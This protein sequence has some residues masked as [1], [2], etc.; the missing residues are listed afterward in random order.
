MEYSRLMGMTDDALIRAVDALSREERGATTRLVAH[1]AELARRGLPLELGYGGLFD[2]C[3]RKLGMSEG[4]AA[5]RA[6]AAHAARKRPGVLSRLD[7]GSLSLSTLCRLEPFLGDADGEELLDK[8]ARMGRPALDELITELRARRATRAAPAP[9]GPCQVVDELPLRAVRRDAE[10]AS[11]APAASQR[12]PDSRPVRMAFEADPALR[13]KLDL[14]GQLLSNRRLVP[15]V[16][17]LIEAMAD[18]AIARLD[19]SR[20]RKTGASPKTK[21][22]RI[23]WSVRREVWERDG[24]R[25]AY[26]GP[27]GTRCAATRRLQYDHV[28]PWALGGRSDDAGNIRL[29]CRAHNLRLGRKSFPEATARA[30]AARGAADGARA[31]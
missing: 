15:G 10:P 26:A 19:P 25:C 16:G 18:F 27:D 23:P 13:R 20:P 17:G 31:A 21:G 8:A 9:D 14:A 3:V 29:L 1:L 4:G 7:D 30:L 12:L 22:R 28:K 5:R 2:Y 24:A 6:A 11:G